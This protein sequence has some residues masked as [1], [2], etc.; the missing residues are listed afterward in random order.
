MARASRPKVKIGISLDADLYDWIV[1]RTGTGGEFASISHA[2]ERCVVAYQRGLADA[3][4]GHEH[5][6]ESHDAVHT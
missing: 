5:A 4:R 1:A 2:I 3:R 6:D